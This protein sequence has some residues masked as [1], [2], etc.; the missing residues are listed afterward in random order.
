MVVRRYLPKKPGNTLRSAAVL[1]AHATMSPME[2]DVATT[3]VELKAS[4]EASD[5]SSEIIKSPQ[6]KKSYRCVRPFPPPPLL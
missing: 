3:S 5:D 4:I 6:D 2:I 1:A